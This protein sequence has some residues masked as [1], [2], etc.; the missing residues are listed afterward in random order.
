MPGGEPVVLCI[1]RPRAAFFKPLEFS[2][3]KQKTNNWKRGAKNGAQVQ[4]G[5]FT[6]NPRYGKL[7]D[8]V[9]LQEKDYKKHQYY[10]W[11][12]DGGTKEYDEIEDEDE[13]T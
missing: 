11:L 5:V 7:S 9:C 8:F 2:S 13:V 1:I 3:R 6:V 4:G 12:L 10:L